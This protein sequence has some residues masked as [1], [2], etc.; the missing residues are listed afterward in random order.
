MPTYT[1]L[2]KRTKKIE[3]HVMSMSDYDTFK[4][5]NKHLE[6][7]YEE[8][9]AFNYA[10]RGDALRNKTDNTWK[11]VLSKIS[12]KHPSSQLAKEHGKQSI[13]EIKTREIFNKHLQKAKDRIKNK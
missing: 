4:E 13:K 7:Y 5:K 2:N 8:A 6:R 11:E 12:E 1:F 10:G 9:P 3:D